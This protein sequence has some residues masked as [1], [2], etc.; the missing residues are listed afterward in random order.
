MRIALLVCDHV[1]DELVKAHGDYPVMFRKLL[2]DLEM[3][4][5][6]VCDGDFPDIEDYDAFI[7]TG[8]KYSVYEDIDWIN[9]L[10]DLVRAIHVTEKRF[11]GIC[12]GHQMMAHALGGK[13][14]KSTYG[15]LI[16]IHQFEMKDQPSWAINQADS[17]NVLM[18]CQ[19]QVHDLPP[20][21]KVWASSLL[22]EVGMFTIGQYFLGI[23]GH[24]EYTK[25]FNQAL[26][27]S[28]P[29]KIDQR[30]ILEGIKT[31]E[32]TPNDQALAATIADF[33]EQS[34]KRPIS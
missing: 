15:Y 26:F 29:E 7:C 34:T 25:D 6:F 18:L 17:F 2:P 8:S 10:A 13:V 1:K 23:Q 31:F 28:R 5:W 33:L 14:K 11:I 24:P 16:G 21:A 4:D 22:C 27:E 32:L 9:Q 12:F 20:D 19:D 3:D 30:M